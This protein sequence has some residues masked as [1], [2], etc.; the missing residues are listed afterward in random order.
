MYVAA[1]ENWHVL[2]HCTA[3]NRAA[4]LTKWN[5]IQQKEVYSF[6]VKCLCSIV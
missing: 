2:V 6:E 1:L 3:L 5:I 4:K